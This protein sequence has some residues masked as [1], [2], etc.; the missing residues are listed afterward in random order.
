MGD[1]SSGYDNLTDYS[2]TTC[3]TQNLPAT[4]MDT[5]NLKP[6]TSEQFSIGAVW[7]MTANT[8]VTIDYWQTE[9]WMTMHPQQKS[10]WDLTIKA[11]ITAVLPSEC[12]IFSL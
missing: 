4:A 9:S 2:N 5:P 11:I 10:I 8:A 7:N 12:E 6:E 1:A 3:D